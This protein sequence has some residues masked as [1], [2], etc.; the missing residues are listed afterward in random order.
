M[1]LDECIFEVV[2]GKGG[3][4]CVSFR[5]EKFAPRGGPDGG[6]GGCG[7][8]VWLEASSQLTTLYDLSSQKIYRAGGGERGRGADCT[9][10]SGEDLRIRLPVGTIVRDDR[11]GGLIADLVRDRE[12]LLV[13]RGGKGGRGNAAFAH[14]THQTPRES[15]PGG[16]GESRRLHLE[17]RLIADVGLVGLPNAGKSTLISVLSAARPR[18]AA[19]PFTTLEPHLGVVECKD[20]RRLVVADLPGLIEGAHR[21]VGLGDRFLRH[22]SRTKVIAHLVDVAH[23]DPCRL[24]EDLEMVERELALHSPELAR[25]RSLVVLTKIDALADGRRLEACLEA[26]EGRPAVAVSAVAHRGL[27]E[28]IGILLGFLDEALENDRTVT[29]GACRGDDQRVSC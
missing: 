13:A 25:K 3:D 6:D 14:A 21:G 11:T 4:G 26:V 27:D 18:I 20:G 10:R 16:E 28:L 24:R 19:Y 29:A 12:E 1:F 15:E 23:G 22:I 5:R 8:D 7:G 17:L 2:A 9:G